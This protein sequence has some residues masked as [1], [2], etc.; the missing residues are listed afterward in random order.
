MATQEIEHELLDMEQQYWQAV[1][2]RDAEA[3][4]R[5]TDDLCIIAGSRGV[6][7]VSKAALS[8][9]MK[10]ARYTLHDFKLSDDAEVRLVRDDVAI[11]AY[12]VHE[13]LTVDG[14]HVTVEA[15]D[16]STWVRRGGQWVCALH[17]E[18]ITGD[19]YGRDRHAIQ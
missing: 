10:D 4:A 9:M 13:E 18:S 1:K 15:S 19:P 6:F 3:A 17:T 5:L 12:K 8:S 16:A 7:R 2:D 11:V 14:K